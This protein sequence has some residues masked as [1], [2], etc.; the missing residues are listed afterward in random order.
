MWGDGQKETVKWSDSIGIA[1]WF[2]QPNI[3]W[4]H[5]DQALLKNQKKI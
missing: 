2:R 4:I 3:R 5:F 1:K